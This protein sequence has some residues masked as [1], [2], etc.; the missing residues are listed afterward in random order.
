[1]G[2]GNMLLL[3]T[4]LFYGKNSVPKKKEIRV[5]KLLTKNYVNKKISA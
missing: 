3:S 5:T 4:L 1:M 2:I